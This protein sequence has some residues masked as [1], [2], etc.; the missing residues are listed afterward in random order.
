[1][2]QGKTALNTH[3]FFN[4]ARR[5]GDELDASRDHH[6]MNLLLNALQC[7]KAGVDDR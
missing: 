2:V 3:R 4:A 5:G 7:M 1:M 6:R